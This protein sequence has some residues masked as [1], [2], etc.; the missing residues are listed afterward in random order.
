MIN[1]KEG[2][3]GRTVIYQSSHWANKLPKEKGIIVSFNDLVVFVRY[4]ADKQSKV[5]LRWD[6][7]Y[8]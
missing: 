5:T 1:P 6:L 8:E 3:I 7:T 4:G 2:D